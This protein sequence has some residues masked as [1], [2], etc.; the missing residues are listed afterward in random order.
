MWDE[1]L[2]V[3]VLSSEKPIFV[4]VLSRDVIS[5]PI[6]TVLL[7]RYFAF[8]ADLCLHLSFPVML[9]SQCCFYFLG[10]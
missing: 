3:T 5:K 7:N 1:A 8:R 2:T 6:E 10:S 9:Q 4:Q